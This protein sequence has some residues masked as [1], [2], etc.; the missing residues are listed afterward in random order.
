[1]KLECSDLNFAL[2]E[3]SPELLSA[4]AAH[5][6]ICPECAAALRRWQEISDAARSMQRRGGA[7]SL[8]PRIHQA[9]VEESQW[10]SRR[11]RR[12]PWDFLRVFS[13]DWQAIAAAVMVVILVASV[14]F[15]VVRS[16]KPS[17][18]LQ[19][20]DPESAKH[21]LTEQA[22]RD[23]ESR[24]AAYV[25]S[26]DKLSKLVEPRIDSSTAP[27]MVNYREKLLLIDS[28]IAECRAGIERN[29]FNAHLR[30]EL[31]SVYREK[32]GTL[33][34]ILRINKNDLQ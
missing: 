24:E 20:G 23:V 4:L 30:E 34:D 13:A 18:I 17:R 8:W 29:R 12:K 14:A 9:L 27:L 26:I 7:A 21:L 16:L 25:Q 32:Q 28:A 10:A 2:R 6:E 19:A 31:L 15:V 5:A 22:L 1:M 11:E 3:G 33:E